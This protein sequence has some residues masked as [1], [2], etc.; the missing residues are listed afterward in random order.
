MLDGRSKTTSHDHNTCFWRFEEGRRRARRQ[1]F[2]ARQA[3]LADHKHATFI[4]SPVSE[5]YDP[6]SFYRAKVVV[7][8]R[9][10]KAF[11]ALDLWVYCTKQQKADKQHQLFDNDPF[12]FLPSSNLI[13]WLTNPETYKH[14][15]TCHLRRQAAVAPKI[16]K[17]AMAKMPQWSRV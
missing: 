11:S 12:I 16:K 2:Y 7:R 3:K 6:R 5:L 10:Q 4:H 15:R 14:S 1:D 9:Y 13:D 8:E 17:K